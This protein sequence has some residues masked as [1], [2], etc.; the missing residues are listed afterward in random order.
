M[1]LN[2]GV[3]FWALFAPTSSLTWKAFFVLGVTLNG[4]TFLSFNYPPDIV[5]VM[6]GFVVVIAGIIDE[7][8]GWS[9]LAKHE[10]TFH[11]SMNQSLFENLQNFAKLHFSWLSKFFKCKFFLIFVF[12]S[13][14]RYLLL[15]LFV[16]WSRVWKTLS[17]PLRFWIQFSTFL[18]RAIG[19]SSKFT[20]HVL[21]FPLSRT[22]LR[23]LPFSKRSSLS[24]PKIAASPYPPSWCLFHFSP[25]CNYTYAFL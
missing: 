5:M 19:A 16:L 4:V 11:D 21:Y 23:T 15:G 10:V 9:G 13:S 22:T 2:L 20:P 24:I 3:L 14:F 1:I 6:C 8:K 18:P 17:S 7:K 25:S 12:F